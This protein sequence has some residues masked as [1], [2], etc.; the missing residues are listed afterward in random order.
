MPTESDPAVLDDPI[1]A[2]LRDA[3][4]AF[5]LAHGSALRYRADVSPFCSVGPQPTAESWASLRSLVGDGEAVLF[6]EPGFAVPD[7]WAEVE[8]IRLTQM[9]DDDVAL[10]E[11][12]GPF[13]PLGVADA[14][15]MLRLAEATRPGPFSRG[16]VEL[17]GYLGVEDGDALVAMAGRRMHPPGFIE[18][19]AVCTDPAY[20][21]RGYARDLMLGV[22]RGIR[23]EGCRGFLH[24]AEGNPARAVYERMG[25][26][27]R[28][29]LDVV[30]LR[31]AP[32]V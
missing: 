17:G 19:S 18:I 11:H 30:V 10:P 22:L 8:R 15:A 28:R 21:G 2:G 16:T 4:A 6:R 7:G 24:V 12:P 9:T 1:G 29:D 26:V 32:T 25:F 27:A 14:P 3:H 23:A 20:R 5:A 31:P 13:R